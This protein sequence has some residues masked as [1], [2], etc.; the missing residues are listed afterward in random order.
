MEPRDAIIVEAE[1]LPPEPAAGA[2]PPARPSA[3]TPARTSGGGVTPADARRA[4]VRE[5]I[6]LP[7]LFLGAALVASVRIAE[8]GALAFSPP[9]LMALVLGLLAAG[10]VVQTG[11]VDL[12]RLASD[13]RGG[14]ENANGVAVL[15]LLLVA[16]AQVFAV[17]TPER[18]L[19]SFVVSTYF[20]LLLLT[21][22]AAR[23]EPSRVL[24]SL[25]VTLGGALL[26]KFVVLSGLAAPGGSLARRLFS[27]AVEG[28]T[29][30]AL[31]ATHL[32]PLAGY[33]AFAALL[34][35]FAGLWL[36]PRRGR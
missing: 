29:L 14:L 34:F 5:A 23:P 11:V 20:L 3:S 12:Q 2:A 30:G 31:G 24:H 19:F 16:S 1:S 4:A 28:I 8:G 32:P 22:L 36:L 6:T 9:S 35:F 33:L 17:L 21:T 18:G 25:A 15:L 10:L 27:A 7:L 13:R 26:L